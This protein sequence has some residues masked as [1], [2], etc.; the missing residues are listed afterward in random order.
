LQNPVDIIVT[1]GRTKE[2]YLHVGYRGR[3]VLLLLNTKT[4]IQ[5]SGT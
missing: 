3:T 5:A 2:H 1:K 4:D